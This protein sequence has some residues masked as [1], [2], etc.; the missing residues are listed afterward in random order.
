[1]L[2][3]LLMVSLVDHSVLAS[4]NP[5]SNEHI[6]K[7]TDYNP[8]RYVYSK[9]CHVD[10]GRLR[11]EEPLRKKQVEHLKESIRLK[12]LAIDYSNK[13]ID[14][15]QKTTFKLEDKLLKIEKNN[16]RIKWIYFGL[17]VVVMGGAVWAAGQIK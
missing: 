15:W 12:D 3:I 4:C 8:P 17:G 16:E 11:E 14:N 2:C 13:R 10:Y 9:D 5:K 1:M 7:S 6:Y